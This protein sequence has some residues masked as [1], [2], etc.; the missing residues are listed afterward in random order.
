MEITQGGTGQA[1]FNA[2]LDHGPFPPTI[3]GVIA[4]D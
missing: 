1:V 3:K 2:I 4:E